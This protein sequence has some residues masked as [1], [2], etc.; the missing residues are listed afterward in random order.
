MIGLG[1][2]CYLEGDYEE[3]DEYDS[4]VWGIEEGSAD[5][6]WG[7]ALVLEQQGENEGAIYRLGRFM[8]L[9]PDSNLADDAALRIDVLSNREVEEE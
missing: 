1:S 9:A 4:P 2:V 8:E 6:H 3:V 5:A 7:R